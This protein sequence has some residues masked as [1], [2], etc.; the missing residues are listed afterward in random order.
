MSIKIPEAVFWPWLLATVSTAATG[1][2]VQS[3]INL[4]EILDLG[5]TLSVSDWLVTVGHDL[6][7]F[8]P[9]FALLVGAGF[10]VAFPVT[11]HVAERTPIHRGLLFAVAGAL[12]VAVANFAA[13]YV[14]PVS[15]LIAATRTVT[16][17]I[18]ILATGALG[19][20]VYF[21]IGP[22]NPEVERMSV[23]M[24]LLGASAGV[25]VLSF[26]LHV[27]TRP[28]SEVV[29]EDLDLSYDLAVVASGLSH[30]W[31]LVFL[32]DGRKLVSERA[33]RIRIIDETGALLRA[34]LGGVPKIFVGKEAGAMDLKLSPTFDEDA[35]VYLSF[36]CGE[37]PDLTTCVA[38]GRLD[39]NELTEVETV[40]SAKAERSTQIQFGSRLLFLP[41]HT[42]LITVGDGFDFREQAQ[43]LD[44][45]FGKVVR[46][47][48]DGSVPADNPFV[49]D[50]DALADIFSYGH[51]N[52][53]GLWLDQSSG[54]LYESEHG[55]YGGDE[56]NAVVAGANHGWPL[57]T[58]GI[59]YPGDYVSPQTHE[60]KAVAPLHTWTPS[61]APSGITVYEGEDF[62]ELKGDLLVSALAGKGVFRLTIR[63]GSVVR[64]HRLFSELN[65]RIR[66]TQLGPDGLLYLITDDPVD[67]SILR[68]KK[69]G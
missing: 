34:P 44:N 2:L 58:E 7:A 27:V 17:Y 5:A 28:E 15:T 69:R 39:G 40:F 18:A 65:S 59:N 14:A 11:T 49:N 36:S 4:L 67:G 63:D 29:I 22:R 26:G 61:I 19:G 52:P 53:Q 54:D 21:S 43:R 31:A 20:L 10:L 1:S 6:I 56:I 9:F 32:P 66:Q 60:L 24:A 64:Q 46:I 48:G 68:L 50:P 35:L 38:R 33:G 62:S 23:A 57:V 51:R 8:A 41:D 25:L 30:P 42:L 13:N 45:H 16:G 37:E 12:G 55:P 47:N 3:I